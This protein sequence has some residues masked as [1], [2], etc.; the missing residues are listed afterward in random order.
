MM[1]VIECTEPI[2]FNWCGGLVVHMKDQITR[3]KIGKQK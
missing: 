1:Y 2:V 3:C